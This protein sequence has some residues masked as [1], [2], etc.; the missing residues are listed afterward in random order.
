MSV[1]NYIH[2]KYLKQFK[3]LQIS[4]FGQDD[5]ILLLNIIGEL[6]NGFTEDTIICIMDLQYIYKDKSKS[7]QVQ[8][9]KKMCSTG[10][11]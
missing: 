3:Y 6:I 4:A 10:I 2:R 5:I 7:C 8:K 1:F 11:W 9:M